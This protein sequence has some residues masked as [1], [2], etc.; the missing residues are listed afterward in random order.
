M[1]GAPGVKVGRAVAVA[2]G[3]ALTG[4]AVPVAVALAVAGARVVGTVEAVALAVAGGRGE[5]VTVA[6]GVGDGDAVLVT[7]A[8]ASVGGG[9]CVISRS[10]QAVNPHRM[11]SKNRG[12]KMTS[13]FNGARSTITYNPY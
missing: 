8:I 13:G 6:I 9:V 4:V 2:D 10:S 1:S 5:G 3:V 12:R 7:A 11:Q